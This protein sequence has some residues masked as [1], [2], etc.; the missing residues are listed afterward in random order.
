[1]ILKKSPV[2]LNRTV[3]PRDVVLSITSHHNRPSS[4]KIL[5]PMRTLRAGSTITSQI[6]S[7][8]FS[9]RRRKTS[10]LALVFSF[11][12][13][14]RA[15]NTLV[16]LTTRQSPFL[17]NWDISL[18]RIP[19]IDSSDRLITIRRAA[20]RGFAGYR[21]IRFLG[22]GYRKSES[23]I[24]HTLLKMIHITRTFRVT[25]RAGGNTEDYFFRLTLAFFT[26]F[27][28]FAFFAFAPLF[29]GVSARAARAAARR[30][31]GTRNGEQ[32]T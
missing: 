29:A 22:R 5:L 26:F 28:F 32:L 6:F 15:G 25:E 14:K 21:A 16:S 10:I 12:P 20:S 30:A 13:N 3:R 8:L 24:R 23:F 18:N 17:K 4:K 2:A 7:S 31:I 1:M 11:R 9:S 19:V 27:V